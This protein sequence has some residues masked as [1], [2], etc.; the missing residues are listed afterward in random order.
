M[1]L[2]KVRGIFQ[3]YNKKPLPP[4]VGEGRDG[5]GTGKT[6]IPLPSIPSHL[7]EGKRD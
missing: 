6:F 7:G 2:K 4:D 3:E 1:G 5:G